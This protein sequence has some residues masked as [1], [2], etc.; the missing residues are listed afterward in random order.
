MLVGI[1][2]KKETMNILQLH[3]WDVTPTEAQKIQNDL[4][5]QVSTGNE[6]GAVQRVAGVDISVK[7]DI[8]KAA[9]VVLHYPD[10]DLLEVRLAEK[11]ATFPYVPGL[12]SFRESP[13]IL[14]AMEQLST[15]PDLIVVDGQGIAHP[16]RLGIASHLGLLTRIPTIGCAKTRLWGRH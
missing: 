5:K 11:P 15:D 14:E 3:P 2:E 8:A 7:N 1:K 12:L 6:L 16:R 13:S 10:L 4:R 9:V